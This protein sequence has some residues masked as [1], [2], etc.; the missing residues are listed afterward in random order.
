M[1]GGAGKSFRQLLNPFGA[2]LTDDVVVDKV[3]RVFGGDF[4]VPLVAQFT[5]HPITEKFQAV[6]FFP[7]ARTVRKSTHPPPGFEVTELA[8]TLPGSWAETDLKKLEKGEADLDAGKD[9]VG[10]LSLAVAVESKHKANPWRAV[11]TGDSDFLTNVHLKVAGNPDFSLNIFEWLVQDDRWISIR[12]K[13][14]RFEPLF[15]KTHQTVG[16]A[17]FAL[18]FLP[19]AALLTGSLGVWT[20]RRGSR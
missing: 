3:S 6:V 10:P 4:L 9:F 20:R 17:S 14:I 12:A 18:G 15:L 11:I 5:S 2:T 1:D 13:Q 8:K 7:V 19:L 16:I